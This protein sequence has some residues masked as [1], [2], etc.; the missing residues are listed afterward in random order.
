MVQIASISVN[1]PDSVSVAAMA[2]WQATIGV[3]ATGVQ[4]IVKCDGN[5]VMNWD[6]SAHE[7]FKS[8]FSGSGKAAISAGTHTFTVEVGNLV[9]YNSQRGYWNLGKWAVVI[10]G[11]MR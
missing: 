8:T 2:S 5:E 4:F 10:L 1:F 7:F 11:V 3:D 9:G 6:N